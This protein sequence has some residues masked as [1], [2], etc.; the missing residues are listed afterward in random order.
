M[1]FNPSST[2]PIGEKT[3]V[4]SIG[5]IMWHLITLTIDSGSR[6]PLLEILERGRRIPT[7]APGYDQHEQYVLRNHG[8]TDGRFLAIFESHLH[9]YSGELKDLVKKCLRHEA[10][11]RPTLTEILS[12]VNHHLPNHQAN[13][14]PWNLGSTQRFNLYRL[15]GRFTR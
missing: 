11:Q 10:D 9:Y 13:L 7:A 4:Y 6:G 5:S 3:D 2:V 8:H 12:E 14:F 1:H 15:G